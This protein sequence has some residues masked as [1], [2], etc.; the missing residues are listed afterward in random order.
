MSRYNGEI[1]PRRYSWA[2]LLTV[3]MPGLGH[4]YVGSPRRG[5]V[6]YASYFSCV[7]ATVVYAIW[8]DTFLLKPLLAVG[9]LYLV[10]SLGLIFD[11]FELIAAQGGRYV[12]QVRRFNRIMRL[13]AYRQFLASE[14]LQ[15]RFVLRFCNM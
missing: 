10:M 3:L 13:N 1:I 6:I 15:Q 11:L 7:L 12:H 8:M 9:F 2:V 14:L 5:F 4:V